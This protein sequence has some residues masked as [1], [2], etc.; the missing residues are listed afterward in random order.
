MS[1]RP[2]HHP[3]GPSRWPMLA[4]CACYEGKTTSADAVEG[5]NAHALLSEMISGGELKT[6]CDGFIHGSV[7]WAYSE[8]VRDHANAA[9]CT[10]L[11][12]EVVV[13]NET[14]EYDGT[15]DVFFAHAG[16]IEVYDFKSL[17]DGEHNYWPQLCGYA[18]AIANALEINFTTP[19]GLHVLH[20]K[21]RHHERC[22]VTVKDLR[23]VAR[24]VESQY[25]ASLGGTVKPE[26]CEWCQLCARQ[27]T[28][29]ACKEQ[30]QDVVAVAAGD[31][32]DVELY[33]D[34]TALDDPSKACRL[35]QMV[36]QAKQWCKAV[37]DRCREL[38]EQGPLT[39]G[40]V[41]YAL[42][43][44]RGQLVVTDIDAAFTRS[45]LTQS[46]FYRA[47]SVSVPDLVTVYAEAKGVS[48]VNAK[49]C[50]VESL[51]DAVTQMPDTKTL[52]KV[53]K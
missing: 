15:A 39:D 12:S 26:A 46:E 19:I 1:E 35:L 45:G 6:E 16:G 28:C 25:K 29:E 13:K 37:E 49:K 40:T 7:E 52:E 36:K 10:P 3:M 5:T 24:R 4:C 33:R 41:T 50:L 42:K 14:P 21:A 47:V 43:P 11:Q 48:E 20:G 31:K 32:F 9:A 44:K 34:V 23:D 2:K 8:I 53:K 18:L 27:T 51:G 22:A 30:S 17:S 38:A